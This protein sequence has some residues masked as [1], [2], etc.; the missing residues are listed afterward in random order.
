LKK[1]TSV[2]ISILCILSSCKSTLD[3]QE[4]IIEIQQ[5][6]I[7]NDV[8]NYY[9]E[10]NNDLLNLNSIQLFN[11]ITEDEIYEYAEQVKGM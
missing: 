5:E 7:L 10:L 9:E 8:K 4:E 1:L 2:I 6:T 3:T 11:Y